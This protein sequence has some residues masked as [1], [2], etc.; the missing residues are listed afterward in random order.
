MSIE[1]FAYELEQVWSGDAWYASSL[2]DTLNG[3]T[4]SE[5]NAR[6]IPSAHT[7]HESVRHIA[8]WLDVARKRL[9]G[10]AYEPANDDEDWPPTES[11]SW[12]ASLDELDRAQAELVAAIRSAKDA[13]LD[14]AAAG[15]TY[16]IRHMLFGVAQHNAYHQAQIALVKKAVRT[17]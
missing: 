6:P 15:K 13:L 11:Q 4:E 17:R 1:H 16:T 3:V 14:T 7:I 10:V 5:A 2:S 12:Q 8:V 9:Q